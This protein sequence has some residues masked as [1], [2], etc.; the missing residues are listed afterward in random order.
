MKK[1]M[2]FLLF[3]WEKFAAGK[4]FTVIGV[5]PWIDY[6]TKQP[7]GT[8]VDVVISADRTPYPVKDGEIV[9]NL[10]E[11]LSFKVAKNVSVPIGSKVL[12]VNP[13]ATVYG[14]YKNMLSVKCDDIKVM[15]PK[16]V[17]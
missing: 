3:V 17:A 5:A 4:E 1:L 6:D 9:S 15:Q 13:I 8:K 2:L 10:Y 12:P 16:G 14:E 7:L 11:R